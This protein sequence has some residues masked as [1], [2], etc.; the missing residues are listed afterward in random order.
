MS[1]SF[2]AISIAKSQKQKAGQKKIIMNKYREFEMVRDLLEKKVN[3][4]NLL[5]IY[6]PKQEIN[7]KNK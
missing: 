3:D 1:T 4:K 2:I 6:K 7:T 5:K